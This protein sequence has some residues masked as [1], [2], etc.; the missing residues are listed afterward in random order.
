[1][2]YF[3]AKGSVYM[4]PRNKIFTEREDNPYGKIRSKY[5]LFIYLGISALAVIGF[6]VDCAPDD[7]MG[8]LGLI[9]LSIFLLASILLLASLP[10]FRKKE[11]HWEL[12]QYSFDWQEL[13]DQD[14]Y[15]YCNKKNYVTFFPEY[16]IFN[17]E[18][19]FYQY[20][21]F[22]IVTYNWKQ[23]VLIYLHFDFEEG[24]W[25]VPISQEILHMIYHFD[26]GIKNLSDLEY[27]IANPEEAFKKIY[28]SGSIH[29]VMHY[30]KQ[31]EM[32]FE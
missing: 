20:V 8:I 9:S 26:L 7:K 1:M 31:P 16:L 4:D 5:L 2:L 10:F 11:L 28:N 3:F 21:D 18:T 6:I 15:H 23:H 14:S 25:R 32:L 22:S 13:P 30:I 19:Y 12:A 17:D 29:G 27:I 24:R